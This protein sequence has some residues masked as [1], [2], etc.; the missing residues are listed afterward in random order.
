M[1]GPKI[2]IYTLTGRA[3]TIV[4]GQ[5]RCEQQSLACAAQIQAILKSLSSYSSGIFDQQLRNIELLIKRTGGGVEQI[6][7]IKN[8][9]ETLK[10]NAKE[11][12]H[13]LNANMPRI[14][15]KYR[16]TE[17]AYAEKQAE[18]K[19]LQ[20]LKK[21]AEKL[22]ISLDEANY[23]ND[24]KNTSTVQNSIIRDITDPKMGETEESDLS[25]LSR[26]NEQNIREIERSIVDDLSGV[27]TFDFVDEPEDPDTR[28]S[29][30]KS[31][32]NG[33]L[34]KLLKDNSL[35]PDIV[36]D[37][38]Q[39]IFKLQM[40]NEMTNLTTFDS[41]TVMGIFKKIDAYKHKIEQERA[42]YDELVTRYN[43]LC[44]M[45]GEEVEAHPY[46]KEAK[47][48][49]TAE[50]ERLEIV[51]VRQQEQ[52]YISDCVDEIMAD[53]GYDLI[54]SRDVRKK[55]GK[56]FR[57]ELFTF[58]EGT[59]VNVTFSSDG[60]ISMELGGLAREDR[61]PTSEETEILTRDMETFCGEFTE[62]ERRM[63]AKGIVVGNRITLSPPTAEYAAII[64]VNDYDVAES[65]QV[66]VMNA[67]EKSR[68]QAEK[69]VMRRG[70]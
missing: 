7:K 25:F 63:L 9:Q 56:R 70:E 37:I 22:I 17:E 20:V 18:L 54:G 66:S 45:A 49:I 62:F 12:E 13:E 8:L 30:R 67:T 3:R 38:K 35:P 58:N 51:L 50:I 69:K 16:I 61:V 29:D 43:A 48:T 10:R 21:Q 23:N 46:S 26:N 28:F 31:A 5:M 1:S 34:S 11:I 4:I 32:L 53:M 19:K 42:A 57:N 68:K 64:N 39:A 2:S 47:A 27:Y 6:E 14:S 60:Q 55:S 41:I 52:A 65:T 36:N 40:I 44:S 15:T 24:K 59:A 33:E